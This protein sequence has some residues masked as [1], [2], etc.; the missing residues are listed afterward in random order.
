MG[1]WASGEGPEGDVLWLGWRQS[2]S[3]DSAGVRH[4]SSEQEDAS[5]VQDFVLMTPT[6]QEDAAR[7]VDAVLRGAG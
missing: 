2:C 4:S 3:E 7:R 5:G 1:L 6:M